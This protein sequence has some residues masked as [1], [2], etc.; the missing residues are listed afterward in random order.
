MNNPIRF[1]DANG[2]EVD[3]KNLT[4]EQIKQY[5]EII[6]TLCSWNSPIAQKTLDKSLGPDSKID[7]YFMPNP[8]QE[9]STPSRIRPSLN[10]ETIWNANPYLPAGTIDDKGDKKQWMQKW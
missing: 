1:V 9:T 7:L 3:P 2:K 8:N 5:E 4:E 6:K 10:I